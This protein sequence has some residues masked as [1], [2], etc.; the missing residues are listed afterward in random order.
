MSDLSE[1]ELGN[2]TKSM[3]EMGL[4]PKAGSE[5][6]FQK[7]LIEFTMQTNS[8]KGQGAGVGES[9][10]TQPQAAHYQYPR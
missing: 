3:K 7:W 10:Q 1:E 6:E 5:E 9:Q 4:K 2:I 8:K